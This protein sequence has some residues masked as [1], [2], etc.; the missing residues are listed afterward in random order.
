M[1]VEDAQL[2]MNIFDAVILGVLALSTVIAFFRGF[3]REILS[4]GAWVGAGLITIYLFPQ[5]TQLMKGYVK[6]DHV[7]AGGA[8][9]GT[10][11]CALMTLSLINAVIIKYVKTGSEVGII[12]NALGMGFGALRGAFIVSLAY[13]I[14]SAVIPKEPEKQPKWLKGSVT[15]PYLQE[16]SQ[17]LA[18]MSPKYLSNLE[19][20]V[21]KQQDNDKTRQMQDEAEEGLEDAKQETEAAVEGSKSTTRRALDRI[22]NSGE[23]YKEDIKNERR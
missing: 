22:I 9:L 16:G 15:K 1:N 8:A 18:K 7:A 14:M 13:L 3:V 10:Y 19:E 5:S 12:D 2:S 21:K 20:I 23:K 4:L 6:S 17:V 11:L